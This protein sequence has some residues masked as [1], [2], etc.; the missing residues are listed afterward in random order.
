MRPAPVRDDLDGQYRDAGL[1][2]QLLQRSAAAT[3]VSRAAMI[4]VVVAARV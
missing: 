1:L 4:L 2:G 3:M